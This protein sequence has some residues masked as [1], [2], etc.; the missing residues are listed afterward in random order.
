MSMTLLT[1]IRSDFNNRERLEEHMRDIS[2]G[3]L[4]NVY[5]FFHQQ[6]Q[7]RAK[8]TKQLVFSSLQFRSG[9]FLPAQS[10][11]DFESEENI[12]FIG[13]RI[14]FRLFCNYCCLFSKVVSVM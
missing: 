5:R 12:F 2:F 3:F 11:S 10:Q 9:F 6:L 7:Q 14:V 4:L 13:F 1:S 8:V